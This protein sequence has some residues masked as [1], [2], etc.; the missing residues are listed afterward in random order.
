MGTKALDEFPD[1]S[2][3]RCWM[4]FIY[5]RVDGIWQLQKSKIDGRVMEKIN[6]EFS[7]HLAADLGKSP[8]EH[9]PIVHKT[10]L[11]RELGRVGLGGGG[12][13]ERFAGDYRAEGETYQWMVEIK[14]RPGKR[15]G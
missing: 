4:G 6:P 3:Y 14:E 5:R 11:L 1:G 7:I 2:D 9:H 12:I 10:A 8:V 13:E 15:C